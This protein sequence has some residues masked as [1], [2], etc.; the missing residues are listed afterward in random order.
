[1]SACWPSGH[2]VFVKLV[3]VV[4]ST[5]FVA[6]IVV[7]FIK[8]MLQIHEFDIASYFSVVLSHV[9]IYDKTH[10]SSFLASVKYPV[11]QIQPLKSAL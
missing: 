7:F 2:V 1:M 3:Q 5:Q 9:P 10:F 4:F 11:S 8:Q 6:P